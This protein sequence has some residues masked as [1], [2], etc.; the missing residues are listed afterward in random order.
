MPHGS[1][2][3]G[4][5]L[6]DDI[7]GLLRQRVP[8]L[9]VGRAPHEALDELENQSSGLENLDGLPCDLGPNTIS[10]QYCDLDSRYANPLQSVAGCVQ[11]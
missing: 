2:K 8:V 3:H 9:D 5:R 7:P 11:S 1:E 6:L 10:R 4:G